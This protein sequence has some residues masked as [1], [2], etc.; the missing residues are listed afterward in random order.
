VPS[1]NLPI[2]N[3]GSNRA[4]LDAA[5]ITRDIDVATYEKAI[6]TAF[7]EVADA[8]AERSTLDQR[9]TA[10][11]K[12]AAAYEKS[13]KLSDARY[14]TGIDSYLSTLVSQRSLYSAQQTLI[15]LRLTEQ[16]NRITLYK[17]LGGGWSEKTQ[18]VADA[19][20]S[21]SRSGRGTT[22]GV[23]E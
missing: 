8:L 2:F 3:A 4:S 17:V 9:L 18:K 20:D 13:Y 23:A 21:A 19:A 7:S 14:R 15:S 11:Q 22:S 1:I 10:Q 16:N 5:V 6:Q 12:V